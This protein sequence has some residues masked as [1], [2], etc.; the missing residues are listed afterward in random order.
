MKR[1][2]DSISILNL[3]TAPKYLPQNIVPVKVNHKK[4]SQLL[5]I[6]TALS[7]NSNFFSI[8]TV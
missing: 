5:L 2:L 8:R 7:F 4:L 6:C 1:Q 3:K